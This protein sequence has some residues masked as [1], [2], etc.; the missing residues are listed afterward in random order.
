[1]WDGQRP[2]D[3]MRIHSRCLRLL[4]TELLQHLV[5]LVEHEE[6]HCGQ[7]ERLLNGELQV[8]MQAMSTSV[9]PLTCRHSKKPR[10]MHMQSTGSSS[11]MTAQT[12]VPLAAC[13][14]SMLT[15][16]CSICTDLLDT[17]WCTD[18]DI[19]CILLQL[20]LLGGDGHTT[21]EVRDLDTAHALA[22]PFKLVANL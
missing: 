6:A 18:N 15:K 7:D 2:S 3:V 13:G 1:M 4:P 17:A 12:N 11:W 16:P 20:L 9:G 5:T 19:G 21:E 10:P 22:E 8:N 14:L